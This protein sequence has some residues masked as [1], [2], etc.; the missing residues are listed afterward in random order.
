MKLYVINGVPSRREKLE[1]H[2]KSVGFDE[3]VWKTNL[4][5]DDPYVKWLNLT[6]CRHMSIGHCSGLAKNLE[7]FEEVSS[8]YLMIVNDDVVFPKD[9]KYRVDK[10]EK[11]DVNVISLGVNYHVHPDSGLTFTGNVGGMECII[12]SRRFI[13]FFLNNIDFNQA[14]DIVIGA[15]MCYLRIPLEITPICQQTSI[16][17]NNSSTGRAPVF[18]KDW[19]TYTREYKPSGLRY[20]HIKEEFRK[21]MIMKNKVEEDFKNRF[22]FECDIWNI[23]YIHMRSKI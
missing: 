21:F 10:L 20:S 19:I 16:L 13:E 1:R 5:V 9:W 12:L 3:I 4:T 14:I 2:L 18:E 17:E 22:N 6:Y 11:K 8:D 15:M 23:D 7:I